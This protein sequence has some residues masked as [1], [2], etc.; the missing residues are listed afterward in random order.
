MLNT[1]LVM[2]SLEQRL[3]SLAMETMLAD[4]AGEGCAGRWSAELMK[5][6][7]QAEG[8]GLSG[9]AQLAREAS[10]RIGGVAAS[11]PEGEC[12]S[13][14][15]IE[16]LK[17]QQ[18]LVAAVPASVA[19][20]SRASASIAQDREL[21]SDFVLE[22]KEHL[23]AIEGLL[24]TIDKDEHD[25]E[26]IHSVFRSFHS[27]KGLAGFLE[28]HAVGAVAH[29][30]ETVLGEARELRLSIT[31][32]VI[33]VV[34]ASVDYFQRWVV[35]LE[36][37]PLGVPPAALLDNAGLVS[38]IQRLSSPGTEPGTEHAAEP[39]AEFVISAQPRPAAE[40]EHVVPAAKQ[41]QGKSVKID[42]AKL[43]YLVD[44]IGEMV[45]AQSVVRHDRV[46][47][48]TQSQ[49]LTRKLA[50]MSSVT[51]EIQR[52]VMSMRMVPIGPLFQKM[53][54]L[55]RD[56]TRKIGKNAEFYPFGEEVELD[57]N[58]VEEL[59]DPLM[60]MIRNSVDHGLE[61]PAERVAAGKNPVGR[62]ELRA[63]HAAGQILIEVSDDGRGLNRTKIFNKAV[64]NGLIAPTAN[65]TDSE[66]FQLIF[67]PGFSTAE[68]VSDVSG[69]GVGMDV[70]N[71]HLQKLRG[72]VEIQSTLGQGATFSLKLP[73]TMAIIDG[74]VV[75]V[76]SERYVIPIFAI[77]EMMRPVEGMVST[78]EGCAEVVMIRDNILPLV[79]LH[80]RF[81]IKPRS[82][83]PEE[84][85]LVVTEA[86]GR[87]FCLMVDELLGKQ[88]VVIK[89]L[90][91][92]F[93][94]VS[95]IAGAAILGD[96][97]VGLIVDVKGVFAA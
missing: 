7:E 3:E 58:I 16:L 48:R 57:R 21:I 53:A 67:R 15:S 26:A 29:E 43:D 44:M 4:P 6:S 1:S 71:K 70:V 25:V 63:C 86:N 52:T 96:G 31:P 19:E 81:G 5:F 17:L 49:Q 79:R 11:A 56:L 41:G 74:L 12:G 76:G 64:A 73:L 34:L 88:E 37:D 80:E 72:N 66:C 46:M 28:L 10:E 82:V 59:A 39:H 97:R 24:L 51:A 36:S 23:A 32:A 55:V 78:V 69:R 30:V 91:D 14:I 77:K 20:P 93:R 94:N 89:S 33:D 65:L 8:G 45:I 92:R 62:I 84:S 75:G 40:V 85:V 22:A 95:G 38:R 42:T 50:Q 35:Q 87:P 68:Q 27:I 61:T 13:L 2:T 9:L 47:V 60:H 90:G 54:R 83:K 18:A